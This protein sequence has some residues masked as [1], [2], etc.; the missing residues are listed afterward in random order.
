MISKNR[1]AHR[2]EYSTVC[3]LDGCLYEIGGMRRQDGAYLKSAMK[4]DLSTNTWSNI[5]EMKC[6]RKNAGERMV[7]H[8]LCYLTLSMS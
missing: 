5:A 2:I 8:Y 7:S 3:S 6:A 1:Q 4:F